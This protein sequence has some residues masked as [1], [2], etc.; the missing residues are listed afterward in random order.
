MV[1]FWWIRIFTDQFGMSTNYLALHR[2]GMF[3]WNCSIVWSMDTF[4][5]CS[6]PTCVCML[7]LPPSTQVVRGPFASCCLI[8]TPPWGEIC[9]RNLS[10][11]GVSEISLFSKLQFLFFKVL[12]FVKSSGCG[13]F[14]YQRRMITFGQSCNEKKNPASRLP[15]IWQSF[16]NNWMGAKNNGFQLKR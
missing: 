1:N 11:N 14:Y 15:T 7:P 10:N 5:N 9:S 12:K 13:S 3:P 6:N 16:C 4:V 2:L 8:E